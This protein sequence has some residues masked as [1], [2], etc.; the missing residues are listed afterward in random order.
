MDLREFID[1]AKKLGK[2]K[3]IEGANWD[4]EIAAIAHVMSIKPDPPPVLFD[5]ITGYKPGYRVLF[6]PQFGQYTVLPSTSTK[7]STLKPGPDV[8]KAF[9]DKMDEP[10]ELIPPVEVKEG[11]VMQNIYRGDKVDIFKFPAPKWL[12]DD[13][14]RYIGTLDAVIT[15]DPDEGWVNVAVRRI[16]IHDKNTATIFHEP[17]SDGGIIR[18]KYW[19]KGQSCPVAVTFGQDLDLVA[20]AA[21]HLPWGMSEYDYV[22]WWRKK[23]VEVI[24]GPVTG[25]PI[26][27]DAEIVFEGEMMPPEVESRMEGPW[28]LD[29]AKH[30]AKPRAESAFRVKCVL[31]RDDP[32]LLAGVNFWGAGG[33][34]LGPDLSLWHHL[35]KQVA[36]VKGAYSLGRGAVVSIKQWYPGHAK[37]AALA[38]LTFYTG[39]KWI[40]VVDDD[41]DASDINDVLFAVGMR[42]GPESWEIIRD[43]GLN[44]LDPLLSPEQIERG[45]F[46]HSAALILACKPYEWIKDYPPRVRPDLEL[47]EQVRKKW[48]L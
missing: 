45:D 15:R 22:G 47:E 3:V 26:P 38:A 16:Q 19:S 41:I 2:L 1:K 37:E 32:I 44:A 8:M 29:W 21:A 42:S 20:G 31:H 36:G 7:S 23:P 35:S 46:T 10:M 40:I 25:L 12:A 5:K 9:M 6:L 14:G 33:T 43:C 17:G 27:A 24:K 18:R 28:G 39:R 48:R 30:W 4:L 11:P 34:R 13:G